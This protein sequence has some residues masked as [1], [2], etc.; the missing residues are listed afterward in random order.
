MARSGPS[1][2][3][4]VEGSEGHPLTVR[5]LK[6]SGRGNRVKL[7][8]AKPK[9]NEA[10]DILYLTSR[11]CRAQPTDCTRPCRRPA[12]E[13]GRLDYYQL[14]RALCRYSLYRRDVILAGK[15]AVSD[16]GRSKA[17]TKVAAGRRLS[18]FGSRLPSRT[19]CSIPQP[20]R[21]P[22]RLCT[23]AGWN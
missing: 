11:N 5:E 10:G 18:R 13:D 16:R 7:F 4:G 20:A 3:I 21:P 2:V 23:E 15:T 17:R 8:R 22:S 14:P 12:F 1:G 6:S 9:A 19:A